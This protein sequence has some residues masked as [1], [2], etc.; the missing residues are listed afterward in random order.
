MAT[1][2]SQ[3]PIAQTNRRRLPDGRT[4]LYFYLHLVGFIV[5]TLLLT[6]GLFALFFLA[7]GGFSLDGFMI[8]LGNL[9]SRYIAASPDR[10]A[11]FKH[12]FVAAH[13][14]LSAG[15]I[16]LRHHR[17]LPPALANGSHDHG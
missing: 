6:W 12:I 3:P 1:R 5:T 15:L 16:V 7:L 9:T 2:T 17:I 13:L 4:L 10:V 14:I 8:Q 11:S